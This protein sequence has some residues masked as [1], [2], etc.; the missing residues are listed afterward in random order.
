MRTLLLGLLAI[1]A[2]FVI[3]G[4]VVEL[5]KVA[6]AV[7]FYVLI[8]AAIAAGVIFLVGKVRDMVNR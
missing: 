5:L 1:I 3:G 6:I 7:L 2:I 4:I 8:F